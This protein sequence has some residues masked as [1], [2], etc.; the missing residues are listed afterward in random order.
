MTITLSA[1]EAKAILA[2]A[3]YLY[4]PMGLEQLDLSDCSRPIV[5]MA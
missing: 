2:W 4:G 3:S 1:Y 5:I